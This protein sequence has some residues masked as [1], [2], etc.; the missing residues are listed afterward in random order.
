MEL[1]GFLLCLPIGLVF[2]MVGAGG[3]I[4]TLPVLVYL[5][6]VDISTATVYS[7]FIVGVTS[8]VGSLSCMQKRQFDKRAAFD[9]GLP[10]VISVA[11]TKLFIAP[12]L[13]DV[14]FTVG[15]M[16][17]TKETFLMCLLAML[18]LISACRMIGLKTTEPQR[19]G[20]RSRA[21]NAVKLTAMG[22]VVGLL[23]GLV[24]VGGG[25]LIIPALVLFCKL[26]IKQAVGT[27]LTIV[28]VQSAVG[29]LC[30]IYSNPTEAT[31]IDWSVILPITGAAIVGVLMG[32]I[33]S[34]KAAAGKLQVGFGWLIGVTAFCIIVQEVML[35]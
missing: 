13:P 25:F 20:T 30:G 9:F 34:K 31:P 29:F 14:L 19:A 32:T 17:C 8:L 12:I 10:A 24:G 28:T 27:S 7:L 6:H 4:L 23:S 33:L 21:D 2:G 18:M 11:M 16:A 26:T 5:F 3:S 22:T 35:K 15:N 1:L